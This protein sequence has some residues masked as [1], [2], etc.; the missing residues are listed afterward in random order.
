MYIKKKKF[1]YLNKYVT[2]VTELRENIASDRDTAL[3]SYALCRDKVHTSALREIY[4]L[5][6]YNCGH[7][8]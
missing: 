2:T 5:S 6:T 1:I 4:V 7:D 3:H 8:M